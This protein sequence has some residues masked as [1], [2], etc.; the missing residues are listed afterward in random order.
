MIEPRNSVPRWWR[1]IPKPATMRGSE[2]TRSSA[3]STMKL[4]RA[5][6][7]SSEVASSP[8]I[9]G[10]TGMPSN[11]AGMPKVPRGWPVGPMPIVPISR[12]NSPARMPRSTRPPRSVAIIV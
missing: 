8:I 9:A 5:R 1:I 11:K 2:T 4:E 3:R 12:P 6:R 7:N 10:T